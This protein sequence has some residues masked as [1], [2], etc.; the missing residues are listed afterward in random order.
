MDGSQQL[1]RAHRFGDISVHPSFQTPLVI[2]FE[3]M[4]SQ[5]QDGDAPTGLLLNR[6]DR[7]RAFKTVQVRHLNVHKYQIERLFAP[8][9]QGLPTITRDRHSVPGFFQQTCRDL[10]IDKVVLCHQN[11]QGGGVSGV[12]CVA[13]AAL[14]TGIWMA[15]ANGTIK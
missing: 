13:S 8:C 5:R 15:F 6:A 4:G 14:D 7:R 10:L 2:A 11:A 3:H 9:G 12:G 1:I